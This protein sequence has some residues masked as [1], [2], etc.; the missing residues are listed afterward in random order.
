M[1]FFEAAVI[2]DYHDSIKITSEE[3]YCYDLKI[4][5]LK[6]QPFVNYPKFL[7]LGYSEVGKLK[8]GVLEFKN[9]GMESGK[10]TLKCD[11]IK[12]DP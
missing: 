1:I 4:A 7:D 3:N 5:A 8:E 2:D 11:K 12:I 9:T 6:P 10:I